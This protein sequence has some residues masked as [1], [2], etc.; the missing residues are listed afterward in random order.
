MIPMNR[1]SRRRMLRGMF[2]GAAVTVGLPFLDC[3]LNTNGTALADGQA[4][5]TNFGTWFWGL[6]LNPGRWEPAKPGK[7]E[8]LNVELQ[9]L[10]AYK[11]K[12]NVFSGMKAFLD[13]KPNGVHFSGVQGML[14]GT[15]PRG[16]T[17]DKPSVDT[18]IAD[19]IGTRTRFRSIEV[20]C[21]GNPSH[22]QSRRS[23]A[24]VNPGEVSPAALYTRIFGPEFTDPNA[25]TFTPDPAVIV[26]KSALSA[27]TED[28]ADFM[29]TLGAADKARLDEY[30]TSL[31]GLE[32]QLALQLEKPAP[33][34]ACTVPGKVDETPIGTEIEMVKANHKLFAGLLAH[35]LACGQTNVVNVAFSDATSSLRRAGG[36]QT[37]HEY[38]HEEPVDAQLGYQPTL[39]W[40][41]NE[42]MGSLA[43]FLAQLDGIKEGD[44]TLLDRTIVMT[45][46]DLG[47]AKL[48][49]LENMP[50][51]TFGSG[52]GKLKTGLHIAAQGEPTS[53]VGLT[54]Q[55]VLGVPVSN[56]GTDSM[57]TS[58]TIT[59]IVA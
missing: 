5:P 15:V 52:N 13:G 4:L 59:E 33:L 58:K 2:G 50:M 26:R 18:L 6:G 12:M 25:A 9:P 48:H 39:A 37:H 1:F 23:G 53:R 28:R 34:A 38:S 24:V 32:Q 29:K 40:F 8:A 10:A 51:L 3:F 14:T 44:K 17:A 56:W 46:T 31:R 47:Y 19:V 36:T 30:F 21:A 55:Q 20:C 45:A 43:F 35:A 27:V 57:Q 49:G 11:D 22:S 54:L 42:I 41:F 7:I 16:M